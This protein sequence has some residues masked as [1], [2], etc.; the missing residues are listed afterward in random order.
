MQKNCQF[1]CLCYSM[2]NVHSKKLL[3]HT[4]IF[5][6]AEQK[7]C[8][9]L[10]LSVLRT[11]K[12]TLPVL[13]TAKTIKQLV[14]KEFLLHLCSFFSETSAS[15]DTAELEITQNEKRKFTSNNDFIT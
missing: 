10:S 11:A 4:I 9:Q 2:L 12:F 14:Y 7:G 6:E 8:T 5:K 15:S 1:D 13:R 3:K